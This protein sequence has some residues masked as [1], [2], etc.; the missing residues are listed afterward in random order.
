MFSLEQ[1]GLA[2]SRNALYT[3]IRV[4]HTGGVICV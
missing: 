3:V 2:V 1:P 4:D